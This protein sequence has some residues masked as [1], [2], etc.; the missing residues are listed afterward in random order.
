MLHTLPSEPALLFAPTT[1]DCRF[2]VGVGWGGVAGSAHKANHE[3]IITATV[4]L[5][6][7]TSRSGKQKKA[8]EIYGEMA[9]VLS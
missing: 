9:Y 6:H 1:R 8:E 7:R 5:H 3:N 4:Q 2:I